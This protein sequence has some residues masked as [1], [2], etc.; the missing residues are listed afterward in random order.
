MQR[1][2]TAALLAMA[3]L[4]F[5]HPGWAARGKKTV[6]AESEPSKGS[7]PPATGSGRR[8]R[9]APN[10]KQQFAADCAQ[11]SQEKLSDGLR[12]ELRNTCSYPIACSLSW[13]VRCEGGS[14]SPGGRTAQLEL[15]AR[16][17]GSAS[18]N[19]SACAPRGWSVSA[20]R[21]RCE[22]RGNGNAKTNDS[23]GGRGD[24]EM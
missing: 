18:A 22:T 20:V 11:Y 23:G 14:G 9:P 1:L 19:A 2:P 5:G 7:E 17:S 8:S 10:T 24:G 6:S 15:A 13:E 12:F 4:C 3:V 16:E 21:W